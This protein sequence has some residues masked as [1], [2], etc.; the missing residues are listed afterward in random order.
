MTADPHFERL[1]AVEEARC[2]LLG[3]IPI[4]WYDFDRLAREVLQS[5]PSAK[6]RALVE[7][8]TKRCIEYWTTGMGCC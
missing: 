8:I 5:S 1:D 4:P 2:K 7:K 3:V 6:G